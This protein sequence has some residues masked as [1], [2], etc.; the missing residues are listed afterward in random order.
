[1]MGGDLLPARAG[2][3]SSE[4]LMVSV[5][6]S[7]RITAMPT[8]RGTEAN[9]QLGARA[10]SA[11][12]DHGHCK[13]DVV[14]RKGSRRDT[15]LARGGITRSF[16]HVGPLSI[17]PAPGRAAASATGRKRGRSC[18]VYDHRYR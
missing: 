18:G 16:V 10:T 9:G 8:I 7:L 1:M 13:L 5:T 15:G 6:V 11:G 12:S 4:S 14:P 2:N 3:S 17:W